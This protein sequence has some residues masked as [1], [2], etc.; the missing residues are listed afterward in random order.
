MRKALNI[1]AQE[2]PGIVR[3][4]MQLLVYAVF[5][6]AY[7]FLVLHFLGGELKRL[8]DDHKG[9]YAAA[10]LTLITAQGVLLEL[11]T[12]WLFAAIRWG[13]K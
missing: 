5:V 6:F 2:I 9:I 11:L 3:A 7:Y 10:A 13:K 8:Y 4:V 1:R 12:G